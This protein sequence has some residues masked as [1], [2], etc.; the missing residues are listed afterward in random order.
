MTS[1]RSGFDRQTFN[2]KEFDALPFPDL[3]KLPAK[4][5]TVIRILAQR[6][7][8]DVSKPWQEIDEFIFG[9]YGL[10]TD[11]VQVVEDT[12]FAAAS[13]R[14]AG[15]AALERTTRETRA[16]FVKT[17]SDE[18]EPYFDVFGE[19]VAVREPE[20]DLDSWREP[21][22]FLAVSREAVSVPVN[23]SLMRKAMEAANQRG[24]SRI[25]V[26]APRKRGILLGLL[27]QRRWWTV[28]RARLCAQHIIRERLGA[29]GL[30][31]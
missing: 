8:H 3:A 13:Y 24:C 19:H 29:C 18:L 9:L 23:P 14:R 20:F 7:Q 17:L 11:A 15:K 31:E 22:F 10:D 26:H 30:P 12:L 27:N 4:T 16:D 2:K 5:K 28:T 25:I 1:L 6:L 21:W